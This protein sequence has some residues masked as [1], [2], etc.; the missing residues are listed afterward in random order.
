MHRKHTVVVLLLVAVV[1]A[2]NKG[3]VE[4]FAGFE[5]P[6]GFPQP[7]YHFS[8]NDVTKNGFELGRKLFY[9]PILS[10]NNTI[11]CGSCHIQTSGFTHH[12][13]SVSHGIFDRLGT[14]NTPPIMNLAWSPLL[15]WDGG[16]FDLDLQPIAP[17]TNHVEMDDSVVNVLARLRSS[18][19]YP[20]LFQK[21][22]GS[23]EIT[24]GNFLKAL[25]QFMLLCVSSNSKYDQVMRR[26][27][28][29]SAD[30]Q[31]GYSLFSQKCA[32]CHQEPLFTD[33]S[34]RN[35]GLGI[36]TVND[37][38]RYKVTLQ[39][40]DR[41][42]FKVPSLRNLDYTPPYMHDG[43]FF[44]L[45]AVL[46]HYTGQVQQTPNL[47]LVLQ[48]NDQLGINMTADE[49]IKIL[50]FLQTLNDRSFVTDRRFSEQ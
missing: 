22:F 36:S 19:V 34:F 35:N 21:A 31:V 23:Q 7:A 18:T 30:E 46:E 41:Y 43:R 12:G 20:S 1:I 11:S 39:D 47:D 13:H 4:R 45:E 16:V 26:E 6:A 9:D 37:K 50:A 3:D 32:S 15:M 24:T 40:T 42:K 8:T 38:G 10:A 29:F 28:V 49:K 5:I 25:S 2:C 27:M 14:R 17:I 33:H 48:Q 44:T